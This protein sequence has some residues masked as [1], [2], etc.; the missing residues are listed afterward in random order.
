MKD[1]TL[2]VV[3]KFAKLGIQLLL[4]GVSILIHTGTYADE[5]SLDSCLEMDQSHMRMMC[6]R[7][8]VKS[9]LMSKSA[10][11]VIQFAAH[12]KKEGRI[13]DCHHVA[14]FVGQQVF[15]AEK[16]LGVAFNQCPET[17]IQGCFHG[18][19]QM[20][21]PH[22]EIPPTKMPAAMPQICKDVSREDDLKTAKRKYRQCIHGLGHGLI[23]HGFMPLSQAIRT[24]ENLS[25]D[26]H[27]THCL[28]GLF[29]EKMHP[30]LMLHE[31]QLKKEIPT[32]CDDVKSLNDQNLDRMCVGAI[33]E[34]LMFYTG[35]DYERA[36]KL[37]GRFTGRDEYELCNAAAIEEAAVN[38]IV[39]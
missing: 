32:I 24:C 18:V 16:N 5:P 27:Q 38:Q 7:G 15:M 33:G 39:E 14:H 12:L 37:C 36:E 8:Y 11:E 19:M 10:D 35:H 1:S 31:H 17:C 29:M 3:N 6:L 4:L 23:S 21:I 9:E 22:S 26:W 2:V 25:D 30:Y 28:G 13:D 20:Y 34:A